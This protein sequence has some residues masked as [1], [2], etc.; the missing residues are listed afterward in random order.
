MIM[1]KSDTVTVTRDAW[2]DMMF[3]IESLEREVNALTSLVNEY[4]ERIEEL[5]D[6]IYGATNSK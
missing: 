3:L 4:E 1:P 6:T 2:N 5:E